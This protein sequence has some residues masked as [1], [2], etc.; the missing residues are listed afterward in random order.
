MAA[1]CV[2]YGIWYTVLRMKGAERFFVNT[3]DAGEVNLGIKIIASDTTYLFNGIEFGIHT[4]HPGTHER[5]EM[6]RSE[7]LQFLFSI[8]Y[9]VARCEDRQLML[10]FT[11]AVHAF[12]EIYPQ[13][14]T[15]SVSSHLP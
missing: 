13:S 2:I 8:S 15:K 3:K 6:T 5:R 14:Q 11:K 4:V 9:E 10:L 7:A 12:N 1:N